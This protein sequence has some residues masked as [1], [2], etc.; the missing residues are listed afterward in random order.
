M[1]NGIDMKEKKATKISKNWPIYLV[2][3]LLAI[4]FGSYQ[5]LN[6]RQTWIMRLTRPQRL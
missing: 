2:I 4:G 6:L 1:E 3:L 5:I